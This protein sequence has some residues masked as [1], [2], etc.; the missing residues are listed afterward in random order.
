[1]AYLTGVIRTEKGKHRLHEPMF[2][3]SVICTSVATAFALRLTGNPNPGFQVVGFMAN[4]S[5]RCVVFAVFGHWFLGQMNPDPPD[6]TGRPGFLLGTPLVAGGW[7]PKP[8]D[9]QRLSVSS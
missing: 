5:D 4:Q 1:M 9:S 8:R 6:G 2:V 7:G 3:L